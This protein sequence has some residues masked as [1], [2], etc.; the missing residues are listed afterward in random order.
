MYSDA[1]RKDETNK[2]T[3]NIIKKKKKRSLPRHGTRTKKK[4]A[5]SS[6]FFKAYKIVSCVVLTLPV[7]R[8][9]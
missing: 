9:R 8:L 4:R 5:R 7:Q 6:L 1:R 3:I 2:K